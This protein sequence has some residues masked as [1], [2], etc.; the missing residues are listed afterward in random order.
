MSTQI[1]NPHRRRLLMR[2]PQ[3]TF[4]LIPKSGLKDVWP[5]L[6]WS[7]WSI[8]YF[9]PQTSGYALAY[10]WHVGVAAG[11]IGV[12]LFVSKRSLF[13]GKLLAWAVF[14]SAVA[15]GSSLFSGMSEY[16]FLRAGALA[17]LFAFSFGGVGSLLR[18]PDDL[19]RVFVVFL[20][21]TLVGTAVIA[22]SGSAQQVD[23]DNQQSRFQGTELLRATGAAS[24]VAAAM[25]LL[26]WCKKYLKPE[27]GLLLVLYGAYLVFLM[28]A[29]KARGGIGMA[30]IIWPVTFVLLKGKRMNAAVPALL[31]VMAAVGFAIQSSSEVRQTL[32]L[33]GKEDI[34][35]GR[36]SRWEMLFARSQERP[37]T[38]YGFGT[39]RF[40][41]LDMQSYEWS[42]SRNRDD[43]R[44]AHNEHLAVLYELGV[45]GLV[46]YWVFLA[47]I[48][49]A[50]YSLLSL[51]QTP[52]RDMVLVVFMSWC[53]HL[54]DTL[55]HDPNLTM[56][57]PEAFLF[58]IKA[59]FVFAGVHILRA[60]EMQS[61]ARRLPHAA[62]RPRP[63]AVP[64]VQAQ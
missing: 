31:V 40:H 52:L 8:A 37:V 43:Q 59:V 13:A 51:Q 46:A 21:I 42:L 54:I 41:H 62:M 34:S 6:L 30:L 55:I 33:E 16:S 27:L 60:T 15:L 64:A 1:A 18:T 14:F 26:L 53:V 5:L 4:R 61:P 7:F 3:Q 24:L 28:F 35:T 36:F 44:V 17:L 57:H 25:P 9:V 10:R 39:S 45:L 63:I 29:T 12:W 20:L 23:W 50:G 19:K 38:G 32:R 22:V 11:A 56:G 58:W 48:L 47:L 49:K 2:P